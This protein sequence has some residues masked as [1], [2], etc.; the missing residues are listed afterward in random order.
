MNG[1]LRAG[2]CLRS[3]RATCH[4]AVRCSSPCEGRLVG[5]EP[6]G[7]RSGPRGSS[8]ALL[9]T[10]RRPLGSSHPLCRLQC[11]PVTR[12]DWHWAPGCV[13]GSCAR[14]TGHG[15]RHASS[16]APPA[17]TRCC[18]PVQRINFKECDFPNSEPKAGAF[19]QLSDRAQD[20][21]VLPVAAHGTVLPQ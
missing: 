11:P 6:P 13:R 19:C 16:K 5:S 20:I 18:L 1:R 9:Q 12:G 3:P 21:S 15:L 10:R 7:R 17:W 2:R 8:L 14:G 4:I